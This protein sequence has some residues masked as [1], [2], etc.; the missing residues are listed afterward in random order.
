MIDS[1]VE[2]GGLLLLGFAAA[3]GALILHFLLFREYLKQDKFHQ[4]RIVHLQNLVE[5]ELAR[6]RQFS[7]QIDFL[8]KQK[9]QT[10]DQLELIKLQVEAMKKRGEKGLGANNLL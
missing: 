6:S 2:N 8:G 10:Q 5:V 1:L 4:A 3:L 7:D 9:E